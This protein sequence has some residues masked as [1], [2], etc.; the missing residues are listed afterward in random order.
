MTWVNIEVLVEQNPPTRKEVQQILDYRSR[1]ATAR[2][3]ADENFPT[4]AVQLLR[5]MGARVQANQEAGLSGHDD[6]DQI[7]Y[8]WRNGLILL[9]CDRDYLDERRYPII[10]CPAVFVFD[11]GSG[12]TEE[13]RQAFRCL[14][15]AL[16]MPQFFDKWW[17]V[18]AKRDC[19]TEFVRHLDG[20]TS[21]NR[22][23]LWRGKVQ[24]W[25]DD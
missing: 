11:F 10:H 6:G 18:D 8:A 16:S 7:A 25:V 3:Y 4:P 15:S 2:F 12:S 19:W 22:L 9:T 17:K 5:K 24:E 23:R 21:R 20:T 14:E 1:R 13:M